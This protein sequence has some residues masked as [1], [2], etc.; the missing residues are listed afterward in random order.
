M[1]T[2]IQPL[3]SLGDSTQV[4]RVFVGLK[5]LFGLLEELKGD[6]DVG[7][8]AR[9]EERQDCVLDR[10]QLVRQTLDQGLV[11]DEQVLVR[12]LVERP[13]FK[14]EDQLVRDLVPQSTAGQSVILRQ[15]RPLTFL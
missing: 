11:Q 5:S 4:D 8:L 3:F 12:S 14:V 15:E 7:V 2:Q 10:V 6:S 13:I 1:L 9:G